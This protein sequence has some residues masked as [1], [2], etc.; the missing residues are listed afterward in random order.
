MSLSTR[1]RPIDLRLECKYCSQPLIKKGAWFMT[2]HHFKCEGCKREVA[3][4]Y[5]DKV[6]LFAKHA[7][8]A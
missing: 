8:L 2:V 5:S 1:L 3:V 6:A 4:T 7:H